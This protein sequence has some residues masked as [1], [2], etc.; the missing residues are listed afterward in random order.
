MDPEVFTGPGTPITFTLPRAARVSLVIRNA[1]GWI[2]RELLR[3]RPLSRGDYTA[4]WNG[5]DRWGDPCPPGE[6][7]C[8]L[9]TFDGLKATFLGS[10]GNDGHPVYR[11]ADGR[12]S[13]G[14]VHGGPWVVAADDSGIYTFYAWQE[15]PPPYRK[16]TPSGDQLWAV[17]Y[18]HVP[19]AVAAADGAVYLVAKPVETGRDNREQRRLQDLDRYQRQRAGGGRGARRGAA[20]HRRMVVD[21]SRSDVARRRRHPA[22]G[23]D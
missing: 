2:V 16:I 14:G 23:G 20:A 17:E 1:T 5:R 6:Y 12:G 22:P 3:A 18:Q 9:A 21:R 19:Q 10:A 8:T 7:T 4:Y 13:I 15:G 11:T